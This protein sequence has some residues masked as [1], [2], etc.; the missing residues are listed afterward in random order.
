MA[1]E[2]Y[3]EVNGALR[4]KKYKDVPDTSI[5]RAKAEK[6]MALDSIQVTANT[7]AYDANGNSIGNMSSVVGLANFRFNQYISIGVALDPTQ[8]TVLTV[9]TPLDAYNAVY[10]STVNWK[11][12]DNVIHT[13]QV[14]SVA[15]ALELGMKARATVYGV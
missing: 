5:P 6:S 15:E 1:L 13:V 8:P 9:L 3:I 7:V 14:E 10:K 12:A 11:G 4:T 2:S